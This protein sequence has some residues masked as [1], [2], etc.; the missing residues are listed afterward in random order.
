MS[1]F[2]LMLER[3]QASAPGRWLAGRERDEQRLILALIGVVILTVLWLSVWKPVADWRAQEDNRYRNAQ[4][5]LDW[6]RANEARARELARSGSQVGERSLIPLIT[7]SA[8]LQGITLTRLQPEATG[9]VSIVLQGQ[10]FNDVVRWLHQLEENN[11]VTVA[12]VAFD[13]DT[14]AGLVN[15]QIRLQ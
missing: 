6:M 3:L 13:A 10:S 12:R 2:F 7:R 5:T 15:A 4:A 11:G 1:R 14:R 8:E 9:A